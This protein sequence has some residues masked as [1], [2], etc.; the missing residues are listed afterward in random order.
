MEKQVRLSLASD[1]PATSN[2]SLEG[3]SPQPMTT[4]SSDPGLGMRLAT[5]TEL[6]TAIDSLS[7]IRSRV[8][9]AL[10]FGFGHGII[11]TLSA[12]GIGEIVCSASAPPVVALRCDSHWGIGPTE[13]GIRGQWNS[14]AT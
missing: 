1:Y 5:D 13:M 7:R 3:I 9:N 2:S 10:Y 14:K 11:E 8:I 12:V 6:L 4:H